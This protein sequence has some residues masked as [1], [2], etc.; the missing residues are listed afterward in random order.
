MTYDNATHLLS[1]KARGS[2]RP[3]LLHCHI[4]KQMSDNKVHIMVFG[5]YSEK[6]TICKNI[7]RPRYVSNDLVMP[8]INL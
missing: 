5:M 3:Y 2:G 8:R 6:G 7:Q 4:V 1:C